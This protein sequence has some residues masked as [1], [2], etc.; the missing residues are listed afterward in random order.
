MPRVEAHVGQHPEQR[1]AIKKV[2]L[3]GLDDTG[4]LVLS[5]SQD[6]QTHRGNM[7]SSG[8]GTPPTDWD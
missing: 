4:G 5:Q 7:A 2:G 3:K 1:A 8:Q 6:A